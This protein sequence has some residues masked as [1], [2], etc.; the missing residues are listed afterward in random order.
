M[1]EE[2][3]RTD[4][5]VAVKTSGQVSLVE[6]SLIPQV[7]FDR[8][9]AAMKML[10]GQCEVASKIEYAFATDQIAEEYFIHYDG[11]SIWLV[12]SVRS[13]SKFNPIRLL[14][15][16]YRVTSMVRVWMASSIFNYFLL[17]PGL[18]RDLGDRIM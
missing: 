2:R 13:F 1:A 7:Q 16:R 12:K 11:K 10:L 4:L 9:V 5:T 14:L 15:P 6:C 3:F 17:L 8:T 18:D